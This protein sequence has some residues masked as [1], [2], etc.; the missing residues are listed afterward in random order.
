MRLLVLLAAIMVAPVA[1]RAQVPTVAP[2]LEALTADELAALRPLADRGAAVLVRDPSA[3]VNARITVLVRSHAPLATVHGVIARVEDYPQ[4]FRSVDALEVTSRRGHRVAFRLHTSMSIF[5]VDTVATLHVVN[6]HRIDGLLLQSQLGPGGLRWD[7]YPGAGDVTYVAYTTWDDPTAGN[8]FLRQ[9]ASASPDAIAGMETSYDLLLALTTARRAEQLAHAHGLGSPSRAMA[10]AGSIEPPPAGA[11]LDLTG[12]RLVGAV[13][14]NAQGETVQTH[15]AVHVAAS[16][17][18]VSARL[19]DVPGYGRWW[20]EIR[21]IVPG[22]R[23]GGT[24]RFHTRMHSPLF[25]TEGDQ[26]RVMVPGAGHATV[27]WR[28]VHGDYVGDDQRWDLYARP[29]GGTTVVLSGGGDYVRTGLIVRAIVDRVPLML[30]GY[31]IAWKMV[32]AREG[33]RGL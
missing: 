27:W 26:D 25:H 9:I 28:G 16:L 18:A 7:L 10:S 1:A 14:L 30:P 2:T 29:G 33:M 13:D 6:D 19:E 4:F 5:S 3:G 11:W 8:W 22:A 15:V 21:A 20:S 23:Q 17:A 32:W 31:S 24:Q 12:N